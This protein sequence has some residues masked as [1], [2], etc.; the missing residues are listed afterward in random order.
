MGVDL[1]KRAPVT[2]RK[3]PPLSRPERILLSTVSAGGAGVGGLGLAVS[4]GSV[5]RA[6]ERWGFTEPWM[7]PTG[8]DVAIPVFTAANL[9]LIRMNMPL[10]W[11][12]W[13]PWALTLVTCYL[14]VSAGQNMAAKAA[15]GTMPLLWV[16]LSEVAAHVY[17]TRIGAVTGTRMEKIRRS[18]WLLAFPSTFALWRRMTLWEITSYREALE[19]EKRRQLVRA[20][21]WE[22]HG[23]RWRSK[24]DRRTRVLLKLGELAPADAMPSAPDTRCVS[25]PTAESNREQAASRTARPRR[26][27]R[28]RKGSKVLRLTFAEQLANARVVTAAWTVE[29]LKAEPIRNAV[30]CGQERSRQLR[31]AL[32]NERA[33]LPSDS[34]TAEL[35]TAAS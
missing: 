12:R 15:H 27:P 11:V 5:S 18:R 8:I 19:V 35:E 2:G 6:A 25:D 20:D 14:N 22:E 3:V 30:G 34:A 33:E 16:V 29:Q 21:L 28:R 32:K 10:A 31:D 4:F 26:T 7:L 24:A 23:R 17:A 9:L 1:I 13:V